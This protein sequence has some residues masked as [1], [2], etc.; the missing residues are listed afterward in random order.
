M[1]QTVDDIRRFKQQMRQHG[2]WRIIDPSHKGLGIVHPLH[3]P[4]GTIE[5]LS[6]RIVRCSKCGISVYKVKA[7]CPTYSQY[8]TNEYL[9]EQCY[10]TWIERDKPPFTWTRFQRLY[11]EALGLAGVLT[12]CFI[13]W[14]IVR[15]IIKLD[16]TLCVGIA[17]GIF[18]LIMTFGTIYHRYTRK[19]LAMRCQ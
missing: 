8:R 12:T 18:S 13:I 3:N 15:F 17:S 16:W 4:Y 14:C 11:Y 7:Y 1:F 9:C 6:N 2:K 10:L 19:K 5:T